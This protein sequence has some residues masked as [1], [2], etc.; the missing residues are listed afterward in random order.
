MS[1]DFD[2]NGWPKSGRGCALREIRKAFAFHICGDTHPASLLR[3]GVDDW[4]DA[5]WAFVVP[6]IWNSWPR[7]WDPK[8]PGSDREKGCPAYTGKFLDPFGNHM[9]MYAV[10]NPGAIGQRRSPPVGARSEGFGILRFNKK[11]RTITVECWPRYVDPRDPAN[12]AKQYRGWPR[13]VKQLGNYGRKAAAYLPTVKVVGMRDPVV[14]VIREATRQ[15]VYTL[16][17]AGDTFRPKVFAE[18]VYTLK[19]GEPGSKRHKTITGLSSVPLGA[20]EKE[21]LTVDLR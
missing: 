15:V 19:V 7:W 12:A 13:T 1:A 4:N 18:G 5:G 8:T 6:A 16:R 14:Q 10:A 9:T 3:Y 11:Q 21:K 2:S 20:T 17:I